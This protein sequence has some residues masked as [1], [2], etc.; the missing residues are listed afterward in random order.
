MTRM[1]SEPGW[2]RWPRAMTNRD[3]ARLRCVVQKLCLT[4]MLALAIG[5]PGF[6]SNAFAT[7]K[8]LYYGGLGYE[9]LFRDYGDDHHLDLTGRYW[10][11]KDNDWDIKWSTDW[12]PQSIVGSLGACVYRGTLYCFFT[13]SAGDLQYVTADP[14]THATTGPTT[15][16]KG[17]P[18][19]VGMSGAAA[20]V[21]KDKIFVFTPMFGGYESGDGT[22]FSLS[23]Y[24]IRSAQPMQVLDAVTFYPTGSDPA[25]VMLVYNDTNG[26]LRASIFAPPFGTSV[27]DFSLPWPPVAPCLWGKVVQGNLALGTSSSFT[28]GDKAPCV[29]FYGFTEDNRC[30]GQHMGR[31]EY[32]L[33]TKAWTFHNMH[34]DGPFYKVSVW[35]WFDTMDEKG[36]MRLSHIIPVQFTE[37][38]TWYANRS[39]WMVPQH[40]DHCDDPNTGYHWAGLP[41]STDT[42]T[43]DSDQAKMLRSQWSLVGFVLGPPPFAL[44][45]ADDASG[46]SAVDYN[47][48]EDQS[49]S[50]TQ[51][52]S[53]T[54][55][56]AMDNSI[57]A[58]FGEF[59]LDMS[60]AHGWTSS[61]GTTSSIEKTTSYD[62]GPSHE[63][64]PNQGITGWAIFNA[65]VFV[66]QQY[67]VYAYDYI[68]SEGQGTY[69]NQD[70]YATS[71]GDVVPR[72]EYFSLANPSDGGI[73]N[74]FQG[75]P[76][77]PTSTEIA[78]WHNIRDWNKGG[79]DWVAI[80]GDL[81]NPAVG[82]LDMGGGVTQT[83]TQTQSTMNSK[84]N[85]NSFSISAGASFDLFEGFQSG[86]TVGYEGEFST[87]TEVD[88][89]ISKSVSCTLA[90]PA[91][92]DPPP[93]YV[94]QLTIQPYWLQAKTNKAPWIPPGYSGN[95][96]WCITWNVIQYC[97]AGQT[98]GGSSP[99]PMSAGGTISSL[100]SLNDSYKIETGRLS[101]VDGNGL[102]APIPMTAD[103]FDPSKGAT[104][105]LNGH[106]FSAKRVRGRWANPVRGRWTRKG[107]VW[108]YKTRVK[109]DPFTLVMDFGN[110]TWSFDASS[111]DLDQEVRVADDQ[112]R[113]QLDVHGL[114]TLS[115]W[116]KHDVNS[117]WKYN[118]SDS[119]WEPYGVRRI[120]GG[121]D[122]ETAAG[123]LRIA[124]RVAQ[125]VQSFGDIEIRINGASVRFPLLSVPHFSDQLANH[126]KV[127]YAAE[128]LSFDIDFATGKWAA[129]IEGR[130]FKTDMVP[131]AGEVH[132]QVL[133]GSGPISD[134]TLLIQE[135]Q[136]ALTYNGQG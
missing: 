17:I 65:P 19:D 124:G 73:P 7:A 4:A 29:Q 130:E 63:N 25:S 90:M 12:G 107:D 100:G 11:T 6:T 78:K 118:G 1:W 72:F 32:N 21:F 111:Q 3:N 48:D 88:S 59:S 67:K 51:T 102:E 86:V 43:G 112:V 131:K 115:T 87:E 22:N 129:V 103:Q 52:S 54:I 126:G 125:N 106:A 128:G 9:F 98:C 27:S 36:T 94:T 34:L 82:T 71:V 122:S 20:V 77:Y 62:F 26:K 70:I 56:V 58:G 18:V 109:H 50:T 123:S 81:S 119:P 33:S 97:I 114:Y 121:Y 105:S 69:L 91:Q 38:E 13:T 15:I 120:R 57:K 108:T 101:W 68:Y 55:S 16:A 2:Q 132:V 117:A 134:Q 41:T 113:V 14:A 89:S 60:Y 85:S 83:Y 92:Y 49:V 40:C 28:A 104:V 53:Q 46:L 66:T 79:S 99:P 30:D 136:T 135:H 127:T 8:G 64:P 44:N 24:Y 47:I 45:G 75:F 84:G 110:N 95:L 10:S 61:H 116:L 39:D 5:M 31:W 93:G 96:P 133:L 37:T 42:A 74:L 23:D 35:P 80:F 76:V